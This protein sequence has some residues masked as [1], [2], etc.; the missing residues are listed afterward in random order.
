MKDSDNKSSLAS[1]RIF[2]PKICSLV[3]GNDGGVFSGH[4]RFSLLPRHVLEIL[5]TLLGLHNYTE[6]QIRVW[7]GVIRGN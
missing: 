2:T 5:L 3:I 4:H 1:R 6:R 7:K